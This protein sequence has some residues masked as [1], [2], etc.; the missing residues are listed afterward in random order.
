[1]VDI[2]VDILLYLNPLALLSTLST[3][4]SDVSYAD[5]LVALVWQ[6][7]KSVIR[8]FPIVLWFCTCS[9]MAGVYGSENWG[10]MYWGDNPTTAPISA[11]TISSAVVEEDRITITL[12]DFPTGT[13]ADGWLA[14]TSFTVTCGELSSEVNGNEVTITGLD[15]DSAYSCTV[16]A[17]NA[18]GSGPEVIKVVTT[19]AALKGM[20][21]IL[22]CS[23]IDCGRRTT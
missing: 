1:M 13:G 7:S 20:N 19:A 9:A 15:E 4:N 16:S 5:Y 6:M 22:I 2:G 8:A 12:N 18:V 17:N 11:P 14:V 3:T 10:E 23:A 21:L